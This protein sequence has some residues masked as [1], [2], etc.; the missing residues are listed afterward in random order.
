MTFFNTV[1]QLVG[2]NI[3][4]W[5][6]KL[7]S[8]LWAK[9]GLANDL[10][11]F[12]VLAILDLIGET[13]KPKYLIK[14]FQ[15]WYVK[16]KTKSEDELDMMQKDANELFE[17][18]DFSFDERLSKYCKMLLICF[19]I[20]SMFPMAP[21]ISV[22]YMM[23]FYWADKLFL[24]RFAKVPSFCTGHIGHSML[25]F[26]DFALAVYTGG[27]LLFINIIDGRFGK[28]QIALFAFSI[29]MLMINVKFWVKLIFG[30]SE[31][32]NEIALSFE[33]AKKHFH[34]NTYEQCNP[35]DKLKRTL[36]MYKE[37]NFFELRDCR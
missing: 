33:E 1:L 18:F 2:V 28:T 29:F 24:I 19:F 9:D 15:R 11:F 31:A 3:L 5:R 23:I 17:N 32:Q 35:I 22:V 37:V 27:Y 13:V 4:V 12:Q 21:I 36:H 7:G 14:V 34:C 30:D 6:S 10:W 25:R 20:C 26:F 16:R 8:K